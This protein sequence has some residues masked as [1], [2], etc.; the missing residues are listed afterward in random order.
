MVSFVVWAIITAVHLIWNHYHLS[1]IWDA[2]GYPFSPNGT[3]V[4]LTDPISLPAFIAYIG[5]WTN[6]IFFFMLF[7]YIQGRYGRTRVDE[8]EQVVEGRGVGRGVNRTFGIGLRSYLK[9]LVHLVTFI[10]V[11]A[12]LVHFFGGSVIAI[13]LWLPALGATRQGRRN[14]FH[15]G[16]EHE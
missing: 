14:A 5:S 9:P 12:V 16:L 8:N 4:N 2:T 3:N 13:V 15:S 10:A 7:F 1:H 6:L 11:W